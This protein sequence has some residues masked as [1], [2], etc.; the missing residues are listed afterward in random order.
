M[1]ERL[2][3]LLVLV[4]ALVGCGRSDEVVL[5]SSV[6]DYVLRDAVRAF[7]QESGVHVRVVGDTEATK[8]T[9]LVQ[10]LL[11]ERDHPRADVWWSS[12][13][14]GTIRLAREGV[15]EPFESE[16]FG[17]HW[18]EGLCA[19]DGTWHAFAQRSR[20]I[21]YATDRV[22]D[23]PTTLD[24]LTDPRW[25]GRVGIARP[26]FGTTRGHMAA[27]LERWGPERFE[28]WLR[29]LKSNGVRVYDGNSSVVRALAQGEID[30]GLTDTD[31]VYAG[32]RN[33]WDVGLVLGD[34]ADAGVPFVMPNTAGLVRDD[35]NPQHARELLA[36][37]LSE[38]IE[39]M[40]AESD[41]R[42]TPIRAELARE[43]GLEPFGAEPVNLGAVSDRVPEAMALCGRVLGP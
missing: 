14:F 16:E 3:A 15:L 35:P 37:I 11:A 36:F 18:P 26:Q 19:S 43:L 34:G 23:P 25:R 41:S 33:G 24:A 10:R 2:G 5:Y 6:D 38:R 28:A 4:A 42:N 1:A 13:P 29:A 20:V 9:G 40:L 17:G 30:L 27:L 21:V 31:D 8:T 32:Q 39:R 22:D 12:E 7:E